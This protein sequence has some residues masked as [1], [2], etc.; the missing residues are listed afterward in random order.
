MEE[1]KESP[2]RKALNLFVW[3][4]IFAWVGACLV[5]YFNVSNKE[6]PV[7]CINKKTI[8]YKDGNVEECTGLGY[9][10]F[11]YNR[12]SFIGYEFGPF[13]LEDRSAKESK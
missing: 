9:K 1:K 5:D 11:I 8:K 3:I 7:F 4:V 2:F 10:V 13:W 12:D 6:K